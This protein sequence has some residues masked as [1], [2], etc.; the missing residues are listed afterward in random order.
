MKVND[1]F[2]VINNMAPIESALSYDNAGILLGDPEKDV[3]KS[4]ICLDC[5]PA[6]VKKALKEG[7]ELIITHHPVIFEPLKSVVKS[8]SNVV[9]DCLVNG[10]SVISMHTNLDVA[11]GGV[12]DCLANALELGNIQFVTDD[13]GFS[14]RKGTLKN[15]MSA[16]ELAEYVKARLGGNIR[17][18]DG[19]KPVKT[20]CVC[21]G[22]GGSELKLAMENADAFIT[23]DVKHNI[24]IQAAS[25]GYTLLDAGHFNTE[26]VIVNPLAGML[27][28]RIKN[29]EFI[30]FN[31]KEIKSL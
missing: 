23:A 6:A 8:E 31:G 18:T 4:V 2:N 5:T 15:E 30:A 28:E 17:Y 25:K 14:F 21:G 29:V 12:N 20:V 22:S 19:G 13:E 3:T 1:I 11:V 16:K 9:Y 7:V 24:F 27:N 10:I 26:N